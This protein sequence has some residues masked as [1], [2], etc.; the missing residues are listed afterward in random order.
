MNR[1]MFLKAM[2][3]G[4]AAFA[5]PPILS[6]ALPTTRPWQPVDPSFVFEPDKEY[7]NYVIIW[8]RYDEE[9]APVLRKLIRADVKDW[10]PPVY[11]TDVNIWTHKPDWS[12]DPLSHRW[13]ACW[14]YV[15]GGE[16]PCKR[17][18]RVDVRSYY[19]EIGG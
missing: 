13:G 18:G 11:R 15:P 7:G 1:R 12:D 19:R 8:D 3:L 5:M 4:A 10:V 17:Y 6:A 9:L 14:K 2:A 16:K